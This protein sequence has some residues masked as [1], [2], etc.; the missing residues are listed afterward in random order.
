MQNMHTILIAITTFG[1]IELV[2]AGLYLR[3]L[4]ENELTRKTHPI[5]TVL[6][7]LL[8]RPLKF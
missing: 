4:N 2:I 6:F 8:L 5:F 1:I 3:L 7:L